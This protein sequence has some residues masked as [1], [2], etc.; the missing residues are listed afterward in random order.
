MQLHT[1]IIGLGQVTAL[2]AQRFSSGPTI[3]Q[4][5]LTASAPTLEPPAQKQTAQASG[6]GR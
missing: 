5:S 1:P 3:A 6:A 4:S 2:E